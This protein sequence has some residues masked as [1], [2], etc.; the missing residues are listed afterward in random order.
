VFEAGTD[1]RDRVPEGSNT[2]I[3]VFT[4]GVDV[5]SCLLCCSVPNPVVAAKETNI[6]IAVTT[7]TT[8]MG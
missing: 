4:D 6:R 7:P 8:F 3:D 1:M 5:E 2:L